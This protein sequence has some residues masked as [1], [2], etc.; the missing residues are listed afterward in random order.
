MGPHL[1]KRLN[2]NAHR[3]RRF[4]H[5]KELCTVHTASLRNLAFGGQ[6]AHILQRL[7]CLSIPSPASRQAGI[8][9][10]IVHHDYIDVVAI[11]SSPD[12]IFLCG[13]LR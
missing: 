10:T 5:R 13:W 12:L 11:K 2:D 4:R 7:L 8:S 3:K 1:S 9:D 6:E